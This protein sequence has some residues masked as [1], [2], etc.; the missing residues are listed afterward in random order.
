LFQSVALITC[1]TR[2]ILDDVEEEI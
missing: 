1:A 2:R